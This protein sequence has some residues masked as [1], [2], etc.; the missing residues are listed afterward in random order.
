MLAGAAVLLSYEAAA[1]A[2]NKY[3]AQISTTFK[4][5]NSVEQN[6]TVHQNHLSCYSQVEG[7]G[8]E[9]FHTP[10]VRE[11]SNRNYM[12]TV[13]Y[14]KRISNAIVLSL[15]IPTI[16]SDYIFITSFSCFGS[17]GQARLQYHHLGCSTLLQLQS[18]CLS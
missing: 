10:S 13:G 4:Y 15:C 5:W 14:Q 17:S 12:W 9:Q 18:S 6:G 3:L 11:H 1:T 2:T 7:Q 16:L 8:T